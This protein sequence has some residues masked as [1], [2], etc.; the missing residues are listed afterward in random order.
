VESETQLN[1]AI[2]SP[3]TLENAAASGA[4]LT[5]ARRHEEVV[6]T[7]IDNLIALRAQGIHTQTREMSLQQGSFYDLERLTIQ[8]TIAAIENF[9]AA[10]WNEGVFLEEQR[11]VYLDSAGAEMAAVCGLIKQP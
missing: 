8:S 5:E 3:F 7:A 6:L 11:T 10:T 4:F 9:D 2:P 1:T